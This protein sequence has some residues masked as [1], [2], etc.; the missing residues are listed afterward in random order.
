[1]KR[2][3]MRV[4]RKKR[5]IEREKKERKKKKKQKIKE[6]LLIISFYKRKAKPGNQG[7]QKILLYQRAPNK[8]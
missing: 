7:G 3:R 8:K 5:R 2:M 1:M 6:E 4:R